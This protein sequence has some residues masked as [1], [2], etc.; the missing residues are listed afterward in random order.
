MKQLILFLSVIC[1]ILSSCGNDDNDKDKGQL[2]ANA[3]I[4]IRPASGV[5]SQESNLT[6]LEVVQRGVNLKWRSHYFGNVY[7]DQERVVGRTFSEEMRDFNTP[8]LKMLGID[9]ITDE[10][11]YY[12]D[13]TY[14]HAVVIT[15][16]NNDTIAYIPNDVINNAKALIEAAYY[17]QN[18]T[19]V[20]RL[21]N[22]AF[23][24]IPITASEWKLLNQ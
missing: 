21:F 19:E 17:D 14:S 8:A 7:Y 12:R 3:T 6:A 22:E 4:L 5:R 10:G 11:Q 9:I 16:T 23:T 24:F 18:Y 13:M 1:M 2:N 20:Y 15:D